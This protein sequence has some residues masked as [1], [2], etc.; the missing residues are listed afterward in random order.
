[1]AGCKHRPWQSD[2]KKWLF[3]FRALFNNDFERRIDSTGVAEGLAQTTEYRLGGSYQLWQGG[4]IDI[5]ATR[6]EKRNAIAGTHTVIYN[7]NLGFEQKVGD[8]TFRF[9]LDE[10]SPTAGITY[11]FSP[12]KLDIA[13]VRDMAKARVGD[14]FGTTS[15]SILATLTFDFAPPKG[16][17]A[18]GGELPAAKVLR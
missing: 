7:P 6:L 18:G 13:Y 11:R 12:F 15:D 8:F 14:L 5:G 2:D 4:L 1:M 3:G 16:L 10:T 9:G 17:A